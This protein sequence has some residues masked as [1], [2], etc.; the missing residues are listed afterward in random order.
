MSTELDN[1]QNAEGVE[2]NNESVTDTNSQTSNESLEEKTETEKVKSLENEEVLE[3]ESFLETREIAI[4]T[5]DYKKLGIESLIEEA[6]HL[7][8][9]YPVQ[10]ISSQF[11]EIRNEFFSKFEQEEAVRKEKFLESGEEEQNYQPDFS[12]KNKFNSIYS[13]YKIQ[14]NHYYKEQEEKEHKNLE[15]RL[16]IIEALKALYNNPI[17]SIGS[18]FKKFSEIKGLWHEAG[19]VPKANAGDVYKTYYHHLDNVREFIKMNKELQ[20]LD[21]THNL[22]QRRA[23]I[24]RA[25]EL[26]DEPSVQKALNE[27]Q[28]LHKLWKEQADPVAEAFRE[29]TWQEFKE[30]TKKLHSRKSELLE[31]IKEEQESNLARKQAIIEELEK[32]T[33][34][35]KLE[36]S[37]WQSNVKNIEKLREEFFNIGRTPKATSSEIWAKFK[38]LLHDINT[39]KNNF[40]K[41]L[42]NVQQNNLKLKNDLLQIAK[43]N[44]E[45]EDWDVA[46]DLYKKI[47]NDWRNIGHVPRKYS[48]KIWNEFREHCNFFFDRYK[49]RNSKFDEKWTENLLKKQTLL[50]EVTSFKV[51]DLSKDDIFEK[52][53]DFNLRWNA[54]GKVPR[55]N[56]NIK[57]DFNVAIKNIIKDLKIDKSKQDE[58]ELNL[59]VENYKQSKDDKKLDEDL[60]KMKKQMQDLEHEIVQLENNLS[61]FSNAKS[62]NPLLK[63]VIKDIESKKSNLDNLK[64][65]YTK[66]MNLDFS[67]KKSEPEVNTQDKTQEN[68]PE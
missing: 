9:N 43:E 40:Y 38:S 5:K 50:E 51:E 18:F 54:I 4:P 48:D 49:T 13:E 37:F 6:N 41:D 19:R 58:F 53:N 25:E 60:R 56:I 22:E 28:Y 7:L 34:S 62:D 44:R 2:K 36:H 39:K 17:E 24:K 65:T 42:K 15:K 3:D 16:Q 11:N 55:E 32:I 10:L 46:L 57:K 68:N 64:Q 23:I 47:Q 27:L 66:L 1:L 52:I 21:Y 12:I 8:K 59:K 67:E 45:S 29:S 35:E 33:S 63:G 26:I 31:K 61:F 20:E 30:V 14:L